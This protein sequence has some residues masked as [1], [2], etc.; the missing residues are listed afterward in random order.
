[1]VM[2]RTW[3]RNAHGFESK[4]SKGIIDLTRTVSDNLKKSDLPN[5]GPRLAE[6]LRAHPL[7]PPQPPDPAGPRPS[8][9]R[10]ADLRSPHRT[11]YS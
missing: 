5:A 4:N 2:S 9:S 6:L 8:S 1:M 3:H 7:K 10:Q 11:P